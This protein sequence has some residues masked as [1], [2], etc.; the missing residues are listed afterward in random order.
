MELDN[1]N[2]I[3]ESIATDGKIPGQ[4]IIMYYNDCINICMVHYIAFVFA[5]DYIENMRNR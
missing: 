2:F 5:K 1:V 4:L 3:K